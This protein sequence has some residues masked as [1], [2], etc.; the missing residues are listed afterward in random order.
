MEC[1]P[2]DRSVNIPSYRMGKMENT[3]VLVLFI[4]SVGQTNPSAGVHTVRVLSYLFCAFVV[5]VSTVS[6]WS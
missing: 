1:S 5:A 6:T 3:S 4:K 2:L